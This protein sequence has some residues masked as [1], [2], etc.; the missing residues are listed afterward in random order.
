MADTA[1]VWLRNDLRI[2]DNPALHAA[3]A[4]GGRVVALFMSRRPTRRCGRAARPRAGGCTTAS[5]PWPAIWRSSAFGSRRSRGMQSSTL[6]EAIE[7][8][9]ATAV[10][11][12]RR[13][14]PAER[15]LDGGD[16]G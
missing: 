14:G 12:N 9:G 1:L 7:R 11:W 2:A 8:H 13:Y 3:I 5:T 15:E 4:P 16:Q 10:F 6:L